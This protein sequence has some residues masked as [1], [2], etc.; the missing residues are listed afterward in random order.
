MVFTWN[1]IVSRFNIFIYKYWDKIKNI[2]SNRPWTVSKIK[3]PNSMFGGNNSNENPISRN[4]LQ[5]NSKA[6]GP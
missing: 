2:F 1:F 3:E 6:S 4:D 5:Q